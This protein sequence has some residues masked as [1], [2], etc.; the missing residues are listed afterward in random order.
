MF[1][2]D[3]LIFYKLFSSYFCISASPNKKIKINSPATRDC[4]KRRT[5]DRAKLKC[6]KLSVFTPPASFHL[7]WPLSSIR[8]T[9]SALGITELKKKHG[10]CIW[11][12]LNKPH[13][14][15]T[16]S[17]ISSNRLCTGDC[18]H[19]HQIGTQTKPWKNFW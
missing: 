18:K 11:Q 14:L 3:T 8:Q 16:K 6:G 4:V 15:I 12:Q 10:R 5:R 1:N 2:R 9:G 7:R 19:R 17:C 13:I